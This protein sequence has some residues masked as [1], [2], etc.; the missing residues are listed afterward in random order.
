MND[1]VRPVFHGFEQIPLREYA[2]RAYLDYSM[3]VVLDRALPFLGDG[4]KPV[5]RRII[6]AMSELGL[7]AG[8]KPKKSARTVGD[9]IGKYHPHGDSACYEA[10]VLMAQPFSYRYPLIEG[11]GNFGSTD[12]PKSFAAMRYT[13][14]KLTPIAEVLLGELGQGTVDWDPNFDGTLEE[15]TW[16]PARLPHLL[17]NGTTGIAVGM[18]TD[19]PPHNLNEVVSACVRLLDDP[20]ATVARPVRTRARPGLP[21]H[22]R[23]H[24][25]ARRPARDVRNRPGQR[26]RPRRVREGRQQHRHHRAAL[27]GIAV[28]GDRADR[29]ADARQE[30]AVAGGHARRVRPRQPDAHRAGAALQ[31]RRLSTQLMGHLFA[32]TDLE[33]SFRVNFNVIGLD[34]RPQVKDLK[35]LLGEWLS[36]RTD[37]VRERLKHRLEKVER[38]LHLL[39]GLLIAFLNLDEVIRI[40]RTEDEP[41]AVLIARF[42]LSE[43]QADYILETKLRQLARLEEMKIRGEQ[44]ELDNRAR[45]ASSP[46]WTARPS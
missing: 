12:D 6:Y 37:T 32:T 30:A 19:V 5:Q 20:D 14:S 7:N 29:H 36:F 46:R 11:Q 21:D 27:P 8:A 2:E 13:E 1:T 28:Q 25:A 22:R 31:P 45:P 33:K 38:R 16:M 15:P 44:D 18:A 35:S 4:L 40:I 41:R 10:L 34:G 43:D 24:H 17:L 3:Y 39:E 26:A 23:D 42:D 9:V